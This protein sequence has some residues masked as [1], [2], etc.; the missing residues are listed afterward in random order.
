MKSCVFLMLRR[1]KAPII[2]WCY[3]LTWVSD[4]LNHTA[5]QQL[6]WKTPS[7]LLNSVTPD[8]SVF[9]FVSFEPIWYY[10]PAV[11]YPDPNFMPGHFVG[12]SWNSGD[13]FTYRIWACPEGKQLSEGH[14]L[15]RNIVKSQDDAIDMP[16]L[17]ALELNF[18]AGKRSGKRK[19]SKVSPEIIDDKPTTMIECVDQQV[20]FAPDM[21]TLIPEAATMVANDTKSEEP[22]GKDQQVGN[23]NNFSQSETSENY[24]TETL[25]STIATEMTMKST[26]S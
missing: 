24:L 14:K 23:N 9:R 26:M 7:E 11:K 15:V 17:S 12:I 25:E 8:I 2:F 1:S 4:C 20:T 18:I 16:R 3:C 6:N 21:A 5:H 22:G 10:K 19:R 13:A